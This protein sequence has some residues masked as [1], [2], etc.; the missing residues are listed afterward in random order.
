[1][2][3]NEKKQHI[4]TVTFIFIF[5]IS[6]FLI[7]FFTINPDFRPSILSKTKDNTTKNISSDDKR[8][9]IDILNSTPYISNINSHSVYKTITDAFCF[10]DFSIDYSKDGDN[11]LVKFSGHYLASPELKKDVNSYTYDILLKQGWIANGNVTVSVNINKGTCTVNN[12]WDSNLDNA[13]KVFA[14]N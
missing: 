12:I 3:M 2:H 13:L 7:L 4:I 5:L 14:L 1:M 11:I 6:I 10:D 9:A 8:T